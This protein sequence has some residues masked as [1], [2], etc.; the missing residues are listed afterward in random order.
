MSRADNIAMLWLLAA[1]A[2]L[3]VSFISSYQLNLVAFWSC[4]I[5]NSVW[6]RKQ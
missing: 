2:Q 1:I 4:L 5:I 3:A 6:S